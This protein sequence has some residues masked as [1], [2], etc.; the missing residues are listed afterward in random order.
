MI[1]QGK[2]LTGPKYDGKYFR[3]LTMHV[4]G[5][6]R[7]HQT[8]TNVVIPSFDIKN[9]QPIIFNSYE[10]LPLVIS[11]IRFS[12]FYSSSKHILCFYV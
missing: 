10:V 3:K 4:L 7:L 11:F 12:I 6:T 2:A 8:L 9:L 1:D 5:G